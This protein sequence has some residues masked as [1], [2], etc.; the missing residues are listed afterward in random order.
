MT[1]VSLKPVTM[2]LITIKLVI[3]KS[4]TLSNKKKSDPTLK[5]VRSFIYPE[6]KEKDWGATT[7]RP[8]LLPVTESCI[9]LYHFFFL[10]DN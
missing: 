7:R 3:L 4:V 2:R 5:G 9:L 6:K 1:E 8:H 10:F